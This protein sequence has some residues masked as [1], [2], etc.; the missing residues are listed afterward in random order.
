MIIFSNMETHAGTI[1][2][3][4]NTSSANKGPPINCLKPRNHSYFRSYLNFLT[5]ELIEPHKWVHIVFLLVYLFKWVLVF[6]IT[7]W[8]DLSASDASSL[9]SHADITT[10]YNRKS[11]RQLEMT[12]SCL[13]V[14]FIF[15]LTSGLPVA[16]CVH[17][18]Q[19][20]GKTEVSWK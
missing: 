3:H 1:T 13:A 11:C 19:N 15:Q 10:P 18:L 16:W 4:E 8:Q 12:A 20:V 9:K 7:L 2:K 5:E 6:L 14:Y 17:R